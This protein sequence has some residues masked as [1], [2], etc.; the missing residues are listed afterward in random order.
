MIT[1]ITGFVWV[2][3]VFFG[4]MACGAIFKEM[5]TEIKLP[6]AL[7]LL[8]DWGKCKINLLLHIRGRMGICKRIRR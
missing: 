4:G 3:C 7:F 5:D 2:M 8:C 6:E 1:G